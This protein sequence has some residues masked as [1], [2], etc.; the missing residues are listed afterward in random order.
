LGCISSFFGDYNGRHGRGDLSFVPD[1]AKGNANGTALALLYA[2][3]VGLLLV[4]IG[5]CCVR[6]VRRFSRTR[7]S[8][9]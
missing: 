2:V 1:F 4:S 8:R 5:G 3:D 9:I 6:I 7:R